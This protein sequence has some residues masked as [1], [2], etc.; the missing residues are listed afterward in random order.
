MNLHQRGT[1][2]INQLKEHVLEVFRSHPD[3]GPGQGGALQ[4]E[5]ARR[6]G[7][8]SMGTQELDHTCREML[9]VLYK[10]GKIEPV[11]GGEGDAKK[12]RWRLTQE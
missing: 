9:S 12:I 2:L 4:E 7:L 10:E 11:D 1:E 3:A 6:A 8:H 5:I